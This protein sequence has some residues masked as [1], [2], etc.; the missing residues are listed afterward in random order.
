M[1]HAEFIDQGFILPI[2]YQETFL[3]G[4]IDYMDSNSPIALYGWGSWGLNDQ[5]G[6]LSTGNSSKNLTIEWDFYY[7]MSKPLLYTTKLTVTQNSI[8]IYE[9]KLDKN[10]DKKNNNSDSEPTIS[11]GLYI[12]LIAG[13][14]ILFNIHFYRKRVKSNSISD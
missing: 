3:D 8:I 10:I 5:V 6:G 13:V 12:I 14:V 11:F 7:K 1:L 9:L 2:N 4:F